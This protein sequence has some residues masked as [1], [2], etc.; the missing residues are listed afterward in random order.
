MRALLSRNLLALALALPFALGLPLTTAR[1]QNAAAQQ[2]IEA[3]G[4]AAMAAAKEGPAD[5]KLGDQAV[6]KLPADMMF[7]PQFQAQRLMAAHGNGKDP[8]MLG[9]VLPTDENA[10]WVATVNFEKA[11]YIKDDDAKN[12]DTEELLQSLKDGTEEANKDRRER[13]FP[14]LMVAGWAE[15]PKYDGDKRRLVWSAIAKTK[16][17]TDED[18]SVNYNTYALGREGYISLDLI[19]SQNQV[20]ADKHNA[21][22]LL[23]SI[24]YV[25]GKRYA[26]F[27]AS[28]DKVA[29]YGLAA[30]VAGV[31]A[32]KLGLFA[33]IAAFAAKFGKVL[34]LAIAALG[35]GLWRRMRGKK[36]AA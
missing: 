11:G 36:T 30:L 21:L 23:D 31:A 8:N 12:W 19:T 6:L 18:A 3:A 1:A 20:A 4:Q 22:T 14:E 34:I 28:T 32:K 17:A 24:Q 29:E 2:E 33:M 10:D 15:V 26:D 7:V 16:G 25:D 35:G 9:L 13:G 5:I 27:D